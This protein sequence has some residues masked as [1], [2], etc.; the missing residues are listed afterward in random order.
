MRERFRNMPVLRPAERRCVVLVARDDGL[1]EHIRRAFARQVKTG[2]L[3][4]YRRAEHLLRSMPRAEVGLAI[5]AGPPNPAE[6]TRTLE[7]LRQA[8]PRTVL[9]AIGESGAGPEEQAAREGGA[10][11]FTQII[12]RPHLREMISHAVRRPWAATR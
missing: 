6:L 10:L 12:P 8:L 1:A 7:R 2:R 11:F 5:L 3:L 4:T 9:A